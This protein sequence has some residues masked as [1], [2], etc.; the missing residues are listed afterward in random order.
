[1]EV[2][3]ERI[4][5]ISHDAMKI[6]KITLGREVFKMKNEDVIKH[7]N[8]EFCKIVCFIEEVVKCDIAVSKIIE[9][10]KTFLQA[11][12]NARCRFI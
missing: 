12:I 9:I 5:A 7:I 1:M 8:S 2:L 3:F 11:I 6:L 4:Y 10:E